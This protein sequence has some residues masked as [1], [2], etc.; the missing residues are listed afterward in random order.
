MTNIQNYTYSLHNPFYYKKLDYKNVLLINR[1]KKTIK[2][3]ETLQN[4]HK[5]IEK[6]VYCSSCIKCGRVFE[7]GEVIL[8][9]GE[10]IHA[11]LH[12]Q[13]AVYYNYLQGYPW[14]HPLQY[15]ESDI[16]KASK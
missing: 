11:I 5:N 7:N 2:N 3:M 12:R 9:I 10:P 13:C 6:C 16:S 4:I 14:S 8:A 15:Y 1:S